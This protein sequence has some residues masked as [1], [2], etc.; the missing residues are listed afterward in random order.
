MEEN[1]YKQ[2]E[3]ENINNEKL[4]EKY[5]EG[6]IND[7]FEIYQLK[8]T[9]HHWCSG[10]IDIGVPR[11]TSI[12]LVKVCGYWYKKI[13][14]TYISWKNIHETITDSYMEALIPSD[15]DEINSKLKEID[16]RS[17]KNN[18]FTEKSPY[19]YESWEINYNNQFKIVGTYDQEPECVKKLSRL[20]HFDEIIVNEIKKIEEK[21]KAL[22]QKS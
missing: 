12:E 21:I 22:Q 6:I 19:C 9:I 5:D 10:D 7:E 14:H 16:L 3:L 4:L 11:D 2:T 18:Y 13:Y 17:L 8:L 1:I 20:L 15:A